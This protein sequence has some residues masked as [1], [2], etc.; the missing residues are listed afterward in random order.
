MAQGIA[1]KAVDLTSNYKRLIYNNKRAKTARTE[2]KMCFCTSAI[3]AQRE[4]RESMASSIIVLPQM[5]C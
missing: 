1:G 3:T 4:P 2:W 5:I